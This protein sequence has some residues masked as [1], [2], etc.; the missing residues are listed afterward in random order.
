M[1][2]PDAGYLACGMT[3]AGRLASVEAIA[4]TVFETLGLRDDLQGEKLLVTAGRTE[5]FIGKWFPKYR[6]TSSVKIHGRMHPLAE[7]DALYGPAIRG[8]IHG[9]RNTRKRI[10]TANRL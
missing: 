7:R 4:R 10:R 3:G 6:A 9:I 8:Q 2:D 5:E 1:L